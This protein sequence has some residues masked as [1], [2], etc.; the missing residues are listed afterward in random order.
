MDP[1]HCVL[2]PLMAG[3]CGNDNASE[4]GTVVAEVIASHA[5]LAPSRWTSS[6]QPICPAAPLTLP[7]ITDTALSATVPAINALVTDSTAPEEHVASQPRRR[8]PRV[9]G[10]AVACGW[11]GTKVA[12]PPRGRVPKWCSSTCRHRAWEQNRAAAADAPPCT[13]STTR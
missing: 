6:G 3:F 9:P 7:P 4:R 13:A 5:S 1:V 11:C 12:I 2:R 8:A 10:Q